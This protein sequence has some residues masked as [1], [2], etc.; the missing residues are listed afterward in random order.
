MDLQELFISVQN[1]IA[2][3]ERRKNIP[4]KEMANRLHC[5]KSTYDKYLT[6]KLQPKAVNNIMCLLSML[7]DNDLLRTVKQWKENSGCEKKTANLKDA[8]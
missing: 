1:N 4:S 8:E 7:T 6:G 5:S 2:T 3:K